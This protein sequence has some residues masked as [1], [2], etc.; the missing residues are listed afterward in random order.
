VTICILGQQTLREA[1]PYMT[2]KMKGVQRA[3]VSFGRLRITSKH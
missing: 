1:I 2:Y 3:P